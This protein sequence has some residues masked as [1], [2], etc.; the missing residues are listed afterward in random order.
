MNKIQD[1]FDHS[2]GDYCMSPGEYKGPFHVN[3][4]CVIDGQMSTLWAEVGPVLVIDAKAVTIKNLRI[5]VT[6]NLKDTQSQIAVQ[7][8]DPNTILSNV[9]VSGN[10]IGFAKEALSWNLPS[11]ISLGTFAAD[12]ENIFSFEL[13]LPADANLICDLKGVEIQPEK[14]KKGKN[15]ILMKT[16]GMRD[17]TILYGE[18]MIQ[19]GVSRRIYI[20]GKSVKGALQHKEL[21][22][23]TSKLT[24]SNPLQMK[25]PQE[26]IAPVVS[27]KNIEYIKKGQRIS[28]GELQN[29]VIKIAYEHKS[30][31]QA[32]DIDG[33]VFMLQE[34]GK[35]LGDKDLI[36]FGNQVSENKDIKVTSGNGQPIIL[37]ELSKTQT[38]INKI[39]I[40]F[41]IYGDEANKNFSLVDEPVLR[42]FNQ[43]KEQYRFP[44]SNLT[45]E[46]TVVAVEIYRYKGN[47]KL[48][49]VGAGY[50]SGLKQLCEGYGVTVE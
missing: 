34:N 14:L 44:L 32:I 20:L 13:E 46:K 22:P 23:I 6:G 8:K 29:T 21:P 30:T 25:P 50:H 24:V 47:W 1:D 10:L 45:V 26:V 31:R 48:N 7:T 41:S 4:S 16:D 39:A 3:R 9:E 35:V 42:I 40:C 15:K 33:Y 19:T 5:E 11:M 36:F 2:S 18:V 37:I 38:K 43:E 28:I 49:F 17:N 12:Q 27:D